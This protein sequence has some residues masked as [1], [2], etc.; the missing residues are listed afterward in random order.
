[1]VSKAALKATEG[2]L[3]F[4]DGMNDGVTTSEL[5]EVVEMAVED[6]W[7]MLRIQLLMASEAVR[8]AQANKELK[9]NDL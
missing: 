5:A 9:A 1:M 2:L 8:L 4:S 3:M 6:G 7:D